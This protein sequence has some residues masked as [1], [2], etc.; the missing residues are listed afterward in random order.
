[1]T[2]QVAASSQ[3]HRAGASSPSQKS[4][5]SSGSSSSRQE[6]AELHREDF[7]EVEKSNMV[8]LVSGSCTVCFWCLCVPLLCVDSS[9]HVGVGAGV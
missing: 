2:A 6:K 9:V 5:S 8:M 3:Q 1:M 7:V 4:S